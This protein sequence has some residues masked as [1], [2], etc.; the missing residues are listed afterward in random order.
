VPIPQLAW[1]REMG[2][3]LHPD[4]KRVHRIRLLVDHLTQELT[5][6]VDA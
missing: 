2:I 4:M 1:E 3:V 6:Y 5:E